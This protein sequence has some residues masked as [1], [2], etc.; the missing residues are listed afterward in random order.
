MSEPSSKKRLRSTSCSQSVKDG[1]NPRAYTPKYEKVLEKAGIFMD[2][3][4]DEGAISD[5]CQQLCSDL[6]RGEYEA[7][8]GSILQGD[9]F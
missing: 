1:D 8:E 9:Q 5:A 3:Y 4:Q 7:P 6:L 2:A